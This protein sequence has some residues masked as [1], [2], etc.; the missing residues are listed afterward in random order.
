MNVFASIS[1][2]GDWRLRC[3]NFKES[4]LNNLYVIRD[5][6]RDTT[7]LRGASSLW[8]LGVP[9][10]LAQ[11]VS[12]GSKNVLRFGAISPIKPVFGLFC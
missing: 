1:A 3:F 8:I 2:Y 4:D 11:W 5:T 7:I 6:I 9:Y 10:A 12:A